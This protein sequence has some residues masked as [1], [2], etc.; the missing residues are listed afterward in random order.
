MVNTDA[1]RGEPAVAKPSAVG[2]PYDRA[3]GT[4]SQPD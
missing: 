3:R 1:C 4:D 2:T